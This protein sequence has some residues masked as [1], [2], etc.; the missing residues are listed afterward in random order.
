MIGLLFGTGRRKTTCPCDRARDG[1]TNPAPAEGNAGRESLAADD[2]GGYWR[3]Q[4][5]R[6][7]ENGGLDSA[8][9]LR[10]AVQVAQCDLAASERDLDERRPLSLLRKVDDAEAVVERP[11]VRL[12]GVDPITSSP[13]I[14]AFVGGTAN[15]PPSR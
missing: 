2:D 4:T 7:E 3:E 14:S 6:L 15:A 1:V 11:H 13:A 12:H 9:G 8:I 10:I 5:K